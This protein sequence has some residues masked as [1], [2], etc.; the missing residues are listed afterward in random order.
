[1]YYGNDGSKDKTYFEAR[2]AGAEVINLSENL[3][4]GGAVQTGYIYALHKDYDVAV[5]IDGDG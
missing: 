5:Q 4:I 3:G 1:M 2:K